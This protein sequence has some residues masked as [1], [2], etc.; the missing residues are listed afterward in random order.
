ML[1]VAEV[2]V[3]AVMGVIGWGILGHFGVVPALHWHGQAAWRALWGGHT[4]SASGSPPSS[5]TPHASRVPSSPVFALPHVAWGTLGIVILL[6][7]L[8]VWILWG[9][10]I[11]LYNTP[12]SVRRG[13]V[14]QDWMLWRWPIITAAQITGHPAW[15]AEAWTR[16]KRLWAVVPVSDPATDILQQAARILDT[17]FA[18]SHP[19]AVYMPGADGLQVRR[20]TIVADGQGIH[21]QW[22]A[23]L[24]AQT[25]TEWNKWAAQWAEIALHHAGIIGTW[26]VDAEGVIRHQASR[27]ASPPPPPPEKP[28][29]S[30]HSPDLNG[31]DP[32][33]K[34]G[35]QSL[36]WSV[37]APAAPHP[38]PA[39][40]Y[41]LP[42]S[43]VVEVVRA[44]ETL[45]VP[46][47]QPEGGLRGLSVDL[48][49]IRPVPTLGKRVLM[50]RGALAGQLGHGDVPLRIYYVQG[51]PGVMTVERPREDRQFVDLATAIARTS[52]D[53][54]R[55]LAHMAIPICLGVTPTGRVIWSDI[56]TWPHCLIGGTT[57]SGKTTVLSSLLT[58]L[59]ITMPPADLRIT[60]VD[61]KYGSQFPWVHHMPHIDNILAEPN[62]VVPLLAQWADEQEERYKQFAEWGV[63]DL[64]TA[65]QRGLGSLPYRLLLIDEYKDIKDRLD[66]DALKDFDRDFGRLGQKARGA[67]FYLWVAT[68]HPLANTLSSTLKANLLTRIALKT[69][70]ASDSQVIL[71]ASG[72]ETLLGKGD[73][74][75]RPVDG[76]EPI[77]IQT[78]AVLNEALW[79]L[80]VNGWNQT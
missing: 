59:T 75:F 3:L 14:W 51:Q 39:L 55:R 8:I 10:V 58:C 24:H 72:A 7:A 74:F 46:D 57:G 56:T 26:S 45:G 22:A 43:R 64:I 60:I 37:L 18:T 33:T 5:V 41:P 36:P 13:A 1:I 19:E 28:E 78:S 6:M 12:A 20:V 23:G 47:T 40:T 15:I 27:A 65:R 49:Q 69:S 70:S 29:S 30:S 80:I 62:D 44:L 21:P 16:H 32:A 35:T 34:W 63:P 52:A 68:Q 67:G 66:K 48:V 17:G 71:D 4:A 9:T 77:R 54:R 25:M 50:E 53:D 76:P 2:A 73:A 42:E 79:N 38:L 61:P 11:W 31:L